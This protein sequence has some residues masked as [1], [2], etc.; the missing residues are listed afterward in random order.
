MSDYAALK[1]GHTDM[2]DLVLP[3]VKKSQSAPLS[4][5][6]WLLWDTSER[7]PYHAWL[8]PFVVSFFALSLWSFH[9]PRGQT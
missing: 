3:M 5:S 4:R 1:L 9:Y 7:Q 2:L 6:I 8:I